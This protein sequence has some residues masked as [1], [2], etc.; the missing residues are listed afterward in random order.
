VVVGG[1]LT[2]YAEEKEPPEEKSEYDETQVVLEDHLRPNCPVEE[3]GIRRVSKPPVAECQ[4]TSGGSE[5]RAYAYTPSFTRRWPATLWCATR[6][7]KF[8]E[9]W[10]IAI[11]LSA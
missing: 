11:D 7:E 4:G 9:A 5:C 6:W 1:I 3:A 8:V 2:S 10:I